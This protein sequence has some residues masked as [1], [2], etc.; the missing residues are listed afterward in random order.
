MSR[1]KHRSEGKAATE[2]IEEAIHLLRAAPAWALASYFAGTLPF[3]AAGL[4]FWADMAR[5]PFASRHLAGSALRLAGLF[6]WMKFWQALFVQRLRSALSGTPSRPLSIGRGARLFV[7]QST[8]QSTGLFLLPLAFV[9]VVFLPWTCAFYQ[10]LNAL[11]DDTGAATGPLIKEAGR[12]ASLWPRQNCALLAILTGFGFFV[13]LNWSMV[14][15]L[16]P[17]LVKML[18]G[19]E[20]IFTRSTMSLLNT[21]FFAAMAGLTYLSVDPIVKAVYA[22]R[23]F[24]GQSLHSGEDLKAELR[25][26]NASIAPALICILALTVWPFRGSGMP[27]GQPLESEGAKSATESREASGVSRPPAHSQGYTP[28]ISPS[29]LNQAIRKTMQQRKYTW[30]MPREKVV[31]PDEPAGLGILGRFLERAGKLMKEW[32]KAI[33]NWLDNF[34]RKLFSHRRPIQPPISGHGWILSKEFLL[35]G[36]L[37]AALAGLA[38]LTLRSMRYGRPAAQTMM[39]EP[40]QSAPDLTEENL[41]ADQLP[42]EGWI[43]LGQEL[44]ARGELRLAM[45]AFY[46]ASLAN[47]AGRNLIQ[48]AKFK[49]N[50]DYERELRRRGHAYPEVPVLFGQNVSIFERVWYGMHE[51]D[52]GLISEFTSNVERIRVQALS[53]AKP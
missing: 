27:A 39:S 6:V 9:T 31:E 17:G 47:L 41:K 7:A 51:M 45:R 21:T 19:I 30:R 48:L 50:R 33:G 52:S 4:Y 53:Q 8:L 49:S 37:A 34:L 5:S 11:N 20:S 10:N 38:L 44:L 36:L 24:Y 16:L 46:L 35:Y 1:P 26:C 29:D 40:L 28:A 43:R 3:V 13:F 2:L 22:L 18:F 25:L 32:T 23:C 42:D 12:Q 15:F 14:C